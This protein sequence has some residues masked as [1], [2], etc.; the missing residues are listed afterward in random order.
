MM[1]PVELQE[2]VQLFVPVQIFTPEAGVRPTASQVSL[3]I[4]DVQLSRSVYHLA[5]MTVGR[6]ALCDVEPAPQIHNYSSLFVYIA[7]NVLLSPRCKWVW[8]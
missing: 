7:L 1:S 4:V 5:P 3:W 2:H 8:S 6:P